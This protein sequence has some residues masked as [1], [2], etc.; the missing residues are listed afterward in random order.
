MN[1]QWQR[2]EPLFTVRHRYYLYAVQ[3]YSSDGLEVLCMQ[4]DDHP[5]KMLM[6]FE[7]GV[8]SHRLTNETYRNELWSGDRKAQNPHLTWKWNFFE[9][10]S[11]SA[12]IQWLNR[13]G[14]GIDPACKLRHFCIIDSEWVLDI[15]AYDVPSVTLVPADT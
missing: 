5:Q 15:A 13:C 2:W 1:E 14:I 9:I 7:A 3:S 10:I 8:V 4:Y 11:G 6:L 12:Y